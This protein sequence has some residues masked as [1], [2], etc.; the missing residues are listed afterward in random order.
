MLRFRMAPALFVVA[1]VACGP[2]TGKLMDHV[3]TN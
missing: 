3:G 2:S 1:V